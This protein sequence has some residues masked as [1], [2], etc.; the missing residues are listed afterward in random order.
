MEVGEPP[1]EAL[2]RDVWEETGATILDLVGPVWHRSLLFRF[3]CEDIE[4]HE[5]HFLLRMPE[6]AAHGDN[7]PAA[8]EAELLG[9]YRW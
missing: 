7:N 8:N 3:R 6:F 2:H 9:E 1:L 4:Q 5:Q